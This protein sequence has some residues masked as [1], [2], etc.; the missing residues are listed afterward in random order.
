MK[1]TRIILD[2]LLLPIYLIL[3]YVCL[4]YYFGSFI[5]LADW[6]SG[7][8]VILLIFAGTAVGSLFFFLFAFLLSKGFAFGIGLIKTIAM[9][10][11][12]QW[13]TVLTTGFSGIQL[14]VITWKY[15]DF[16]KTAHIVTLL[17]F[18]FGVFVTF[19]YILFIMVSQPEMKAE[20]AQTEDDRFKLKG[21]DKF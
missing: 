18:L 17:L 16:S 20:K 9:K 15:L 11:I 19:G 14:L 12:A 5:A 1:P 13:L 8:N 4:T 7:R 21:L 2:I 3:M 6:L 10:K